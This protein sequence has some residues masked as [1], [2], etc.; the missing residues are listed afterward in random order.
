MEIEKVIRK[1]NV[2]MNTINAAV[3]D[4]KKML[5]NLTEEN[6]HVLISSIEIIKKK[7]NEVI[8]KFDKIIDEIDDVS[9]G[10][11][12]SAKSYKF[13]LEINKHLS[14]V[15]EKLKSKVIN[16][17]RDA[18][19]VSQTNKQVSVRLPKIEIK[20][21][22]GDATEWQTFYDSFECAVH[23]NKQISNI[24]KM[25]YLINLLEGEAASTLKGLQLS[26]A[27]YEVALNMLQERYG[28]EQVLIS[29]FMNKL[30]N[31][32]P[33]CGLSAVKELRQ[34]YDTIE[35]QVRSLNS[36][37]LNER[38]YGAMLVPVVMSKLPQEVKLVITRQFG[39][40]SWD[41]KLVLGALR[42]ELEAREKV[43]LTDVVES[44]DI[45]IATS[46]M[47]L[48]ATANPVKYPCVYCKKT[49]H[50]AFQCRTVTNE[51]AR[52]NIL[53]KEKRCLLCLKPGHFVRDCYSKTKCFT[54]K[55]K[56]NSSICP[57][58]KQEGKN[59]DDKNE[60][61]VNLLT[62]N[63]LNSV[64][65]MTASTEAM[66]VDNKNV[67]HVRILFDSGS[68]L[69]YVTPRIKSLLK[70]DTLSK[71]DMCIKTFG[72]SRQNKSMDYVKL[73]IKTE[74]GNVAVSALVS[75]I[76]YPLRN[77]NLSYAKK[78]YNHLK[79]LKLADS[80]DDNTPLDVDVLIGADLYWQ[81]IDAKIIKRGKAGDPVAVSSSLG[82][83][84]SGQINQ[85]SEVSTSMIVNTHVLK[86]DVST[87][88][89]LDLTKTVNK[90]WDIESLGININDLKQNEKSVL[91]DFENNIEFSESTKRYEV[92]FPMRDDHGILGDNYSLCENRLKSL[93]KKFENDKHLLK[94]YASIIQEQL[95]L[96]VIELAPKDHEIG[97]THYLPHKP[98]VRKEKSTTK[99]RM[100]YDA[101][102][103]EKGCCSLNECL[104]PG[105][106]L[107]T[108]LF[109]ILLRFRANNIAIVSDV[110][111]AFLQI[112]LHNS[113]RDL[114]RFLWF[115]DV[116]KI[117]F[118]D[119][120]K[121][122]L[123]EY[124]LCRV[125][126]GVTSS[127]F[128][129]SATI[130][131]HANL[132]K[133]ID[134]DFVEKF[135]LSLHVDDLNACSTDIVEAYEFFCKSKERLK[136]ASFNLRKFQSNSVEL[137]DMVRNQFGEK[138]NP[139]TENESKILGVIWDKIN[140]ELSFDF[141][142]IASKFK[143]NATK[144]QVIQAIASI[145][146]PLGLINPVVV[147][148]KIFFQ[149]LCVIKL[150]WDEKLPE[151]LFDEWRELIN[152]LK[153]VNEIK[154][155]R[156][157]CLH[158]KND[159][160]EK[161]EL[162]GFSDAS[163]KA[164]GCCVYLR[165]VHQSGKI[166]TSLVTSKS[167]ISPMKTLTIPKL[168][169]LGALL[170]SRLLPVIEKSLSPVID[171]TKTIAWID[172]SV[173][174]SWMTNDSK[175]YK[176]FIQNRVNEIR[177]NVNVDIWRLINSSNNPADIISRGCKPAQIVDNDLWSH[178]PPFLI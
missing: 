89:D 110:E 169:L 90:F 1:K 55:G 6:I 18:K 72:G 81:F 51:S 36:L 166:K 96:N 53:I 161:I 146:D 88:P 69:N 165:F 8:E 76:S 45:S 131:H 99:V 157:Y 140:D 147:K 86:C 158:D 62:N 44:D 163:G 82:F 125:L 148:F 64:L 22:N 133:D 101:S 12:E 172:S 50:K 52:K 37:G 126:F 105:P 27:N 34:L 100:V 57:G 178:G 171:I 154:F 54:C 23:K 68:Q 113:Q 17:T 93:T 108:K 144:R 21:F 117:N 48:N 78:K 155:E 167:R 10:T 70:L 174:Y 168:E 87:N 98:V 139:K 109:D 35:T 175:T 92:K 112:D 103:K 58:K 11:E 176:T 14:E 150:N 123:V 111:K 61:A 3:A 142:E 79:G 106:S 56:H 46:G 162:Q 49:S 26:N 151:Q 128:L 74:K 122:E 31:L 47:T 132:Y 19:T 114:V 29:S 118:D 83:I 127:P 15:K 119:F 66:S 129:L 138:E 65:L 77:Q 97:N 2:L 173:A 152:E 102:A 38:N 94:E 40:N 28:D 130:I 104:D 121:N 135:L 80:N 4:N 164:Y 73:S 67:A 41:I 143:E 149:K 33:V 7:L 156:N 134:P 60:D 115:K 124:R 107:T 63:E 16:E 95:N 9:L 84:L 39:K 5:D 20:R 116:N 13:E 160:F 71:K 75:E 30:L 42:A 91:N 137:E 25:N 153:E 159:P 141:N 43:Y 32:E 177:N 170:L 85:S 120:S 24:E 59:D 145:Y 136:E